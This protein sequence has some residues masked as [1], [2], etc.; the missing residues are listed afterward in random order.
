[1]RC[2]PLSRA[3]GFKGKIR[4]MELD[5]LKLLF[6]IVSTVI[7]V[8]VTFYLKEYLQSKK[9]YKSLKKKLESVAGRNAYI[10]YTGEGSGVGGNLYKITDIDQ[11]GI[12]LKNSI[13]TIFLPPKLLLNSPMIV[14]EDDYE[15]LKKEYQAREIQN[16]VESMFEPMFTRMIQ[17][18]ESDLNSDDG[19]LSSQIELRVIQVLETKGVLSQISTSELNRLQH[20]AEKA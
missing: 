18:I 19:E 1:M 16:V 3:L 15:R 6:V 13:Q 20:I 8:A 4:I 9:E 17:E 2:S 11:G 10:V 5:Y 14:P 12:T 7:S